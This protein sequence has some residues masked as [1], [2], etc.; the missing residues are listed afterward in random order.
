MTPLAIE[1]VQTVLHLLQGY[2]IFLRPM[3]QDKLLKVQECTFMRNFLPDLNKSLPSVLCG[4]S[5][6]VGTL[7]VLNQIFDFKYLL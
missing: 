7:S 2:C 3:F 1:K 6:T 5:R 4:Q